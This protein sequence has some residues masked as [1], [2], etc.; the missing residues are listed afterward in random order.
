MRTLRGQAFAWGFYNKVVMQGSTN[1][2]SNYVTLNGFKWN[3]IQLLAHE[4]TYCLQFDK[5]GF[6]K[7]KPIANIPNW[8]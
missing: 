8:K 2:T 4:M 3:L 5:L 1:C 6:W 7:S